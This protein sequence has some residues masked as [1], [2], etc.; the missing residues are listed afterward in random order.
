MKLQY[1]ESLS[2]FAFKSNKRRYT[3]AAELRDRVAHLE[4]DAEVGPAAA[5]PPRHTSLF[6]PSCLELSAKL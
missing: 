6:K 1:D 4:R 5:T 3:T 2:D